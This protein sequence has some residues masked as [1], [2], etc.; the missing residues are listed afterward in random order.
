MGV[1]TEQK[2]K[3]RVT[4]LYDFLMTNHP[5]DFTHEGN[6]LRMKTNHSISV[7]RDYSGF[8]DF[9]TGEKGN[10]IDFLEKYM[11]Y[12][13]LEAVSALVGQEPIKESIPTPSISSEGMEFNSLSASFPEPTRG[14][15]N[16]LFAYLMKQRCISNDIIQFLIDEKL[17]YQDEANGNIVFVNKDRD[18]GEIHGTYSEKSF[19]GMIPNSTSDGYW[20]FKPNGDDISVIYVCEAAIDAI[21]L[22][23]LNRI[24]HINES[25]AYASIGGAG[26]QQAINRI[27]EQNIRVVIA[28]DNDKAGSTCRIKNLELASAIPNLNDWNDDLREIR[29]KEISLN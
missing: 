23:E 10:S 12:T 25:A 11:G 22:Y 18:W 13:F 24:N 21:S 4:N 20:S 1:F 17:M 7:R 2:R 9:S 28:V 5:D 19:H 14:R 27:K 29:K 6:S 15:Y 16:K 8:Q 3:A 26:K